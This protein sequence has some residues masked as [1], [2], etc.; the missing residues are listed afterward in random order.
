M[1]RELQ[2]TLNVSDEFVSA[3][4]KLCDDHPKD[5]MQLFP[6]GI[7]IT[8]YM[9]KPSIKVRQLTKEQR[10]G[11]AVRDYEDTTLLHF[12]ESALEGER[13]LWNA[14]PLD[15]EYAL[16]RLEAEVKRRDLKLKEDSDD[17]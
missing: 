15:Q 14:E 1:K 4:H 2:K 13:M 16:E 6:D 17:N 5:F 9:D 11:I 8:W 7:S 3:L 12:Y 10:F